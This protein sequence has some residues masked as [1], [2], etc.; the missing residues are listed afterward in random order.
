[1]NA[2]DWRKAYPGI[3]WNDPHNF[4]IAWD[5]A[6]IAEREACAKLCEERADASW[7]EEET[8]FSRACANDIRARSNA[9][10]HRHAGGDDKTN[11]DGSGM[12][13]A[14]QS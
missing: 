7:S 12:S 9:G 3:N 6:S 11:N 8:I 2:K 10:A 5:A 1:M 14:A 13:G 4:Q